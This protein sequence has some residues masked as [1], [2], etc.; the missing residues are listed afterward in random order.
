MCHL[1]IEYQ[2]SM[3]TAAAIYLL[4]GIYL[5]VFSRE[6][7]TTSFSSSS[8]YLLNE[9]CFFNQV[10]ATFMRI[11][12]GVGLIELL[13]FTQYCSPFFRLPMDYSL[14]K[15]CKNKETLEVTVLFL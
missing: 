7:V 8:L 11:N 4:L 6:E 12:L 15:A 9:D 5:K 14:H 10:F 3:L 2:Q 1:T 13:P